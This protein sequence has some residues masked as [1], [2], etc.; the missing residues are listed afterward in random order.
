MELATEQQPMT[1]VAGTVSAEDSPNVALASDVEPEQV[2]AT[3]ELPTVGDNEQ[4][5]SMDAMKRLQLLFDGVQK[6]ARVHDIFDADADGTV[7]ATDLI[8]IAKG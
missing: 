6:I 3:A 8:Q 7:S 2:V 5:V 1:P 4:Q